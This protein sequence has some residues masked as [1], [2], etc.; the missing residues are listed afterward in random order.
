MRFVA[1]VLFYVQFVLHLALVLTNLASIFV[2]PFKAEWFIASPLCTILG[3][4]LFSK[5]FDC[6]ITK[7]ENW[8]RVQL[9]LPQIKSFIGHYIF[10]YIY[11]TWEFLTR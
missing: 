9:E 11:I 4:I 8:L 2:L 6:P 1:W 3:I 10:K 5:S 7:F